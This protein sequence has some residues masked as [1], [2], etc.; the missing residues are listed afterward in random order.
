MSELGSF[1]CIVRRRAGSRL[2]VEAPPALYNLLTL[3]RNQAIPG[4]V[5]GYDRRQRQMCIRDSI[6]KCPIRIHGAAFAQSMEQLFGAVRSRWAAQRSMEQRLRTG[7]RVPAQ[8]RQCAGGGSQPRRLL[9]TKLEALSSLLNS[10]RAAAGGDAST[11][12]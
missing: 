11:L 4:E 7:S 5:Q 2:R 8:T 12:S 6:N 10:P 3:V 9:V 1:G